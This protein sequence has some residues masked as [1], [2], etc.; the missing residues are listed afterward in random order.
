MGECNITYIYEILVVIHFGNVI[1]V[2]NF[3][4]IL[5]LQYYTNYDLA[6]RSFGKYFLFFSV[7]SCEI[8]E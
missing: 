5:S 8:I 1:F 3:E 7:I 4:W 2:V 6:F